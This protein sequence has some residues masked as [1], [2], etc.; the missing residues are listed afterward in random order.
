MTGM[1]E[2]SFQPLDENIDRRSL[3]WLRFGLCRSECADRFRVEQRAYG[4]VDGLQF[5]IAKSVIQT[6]NTAS[7]EHVAQ[8]SPGARTFIAEIAPIQID[9]ALIGSELDV[10]AFAGDI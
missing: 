4:V 3:R 1:I 9:K 2:Q 8:G 7:G 5:E 6:R 10:Q